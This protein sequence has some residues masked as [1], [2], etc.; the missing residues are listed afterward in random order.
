[1]DVYPL[2]TCTWLT[3]VADFRR[4]AHDRPSVNSSYDYKELVLRLMRQPALAMSTHMPL[5]SCITPTIGYRTGTA[6]SG[7]DRFLLIGGA[8]RHA[9]YGKRTQSLNLMISR[10]TSALVHLPSL[11][12]PLQSIDTNKDRSPLIAQEDAYSQFVKLNKFFEASR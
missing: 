5:F 12:L 3:P 8:R 2:P 6:A 10:K 11:V 9:V 7:P 1:M 4:S